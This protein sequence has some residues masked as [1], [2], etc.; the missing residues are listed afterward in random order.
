V[1]ERSAGGDIAAHPASFRDPAGFLFRRD[2]VLYRQV[3][4]AGREDYER[5]MAS[6]LYEALA[7]DGLLVRH[8]EVSPA[9]AAAPDACRVLKPERI[10]FVSYPFEWCFGQ[11]RDASLLTLQ[12]MERALDHGMALKDASAINVQFR[13]P[14]PVFV[15][16]LSFERYREGRPWVAYRQFCRHFLAPLLLVSDRDPTLGRLSAV[17]PDGV[18][19]RTASRML[20]A[21]S[22]L[23]PSRLFHV[24]MHARSIARHAEPGPGAERAR[25]GRMDER[26]L[27]GL[28]S[29]LQDTVRGLDFDPG[30][31][32]WAGYARDHGY[33]REGLELKKELVGRLL[34]GCGP[35][36][37]WD[38]G[39]NTGAFSRVAA[40]AGRDVVALDADPGATELHYRALRGERAPSGPGWTL[41][42]LVDL[43]SPTAAG[44]WAGRE[45]S[46]LEDRG[47]AGVLLALALVHHLAI[48][49]NVPF[50][51][52]AEWMARLGRDLLIEF[53]PR[54]DPQVGRLLVSRADVFPWYGRER[55]E[56][57]FSARFELRERLPV[58]SS[59]RWL[60]WMRREVERG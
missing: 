4:Q 25:R 44:G 15:D 35:G 26:A 43:A 10:P 51:L 57:A 41:P 50:D 46:S 45:R 12:L 27:R 28:L 3:R 36:P 33:G 60:Y 59:G 9:L 47:P 39:A 53:V 7:A 23:R 13:G 42:L 22:W 2:G 6:G 54:E 21:A 16:T 24:H 58:G 56:E 11:L 8:E 1:T 17:F 52:Q 49:S 18:P 5:L 31:T 38:L 14:R 32:E 37:V 20:P 40:A 34:E 30:G 19:L 29:S 55:F 48:G